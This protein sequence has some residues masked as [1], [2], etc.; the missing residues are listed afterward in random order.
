MTSPTDTSRQK[1]ACQS[2]GARTIHVFNVARNCAGDWIARIS[3]NL[4]RKRSYFSTGGSVLT[5]QAPRKALRRPS[6]TPSAMPCSTGTGSPFPRRRPYRARTPT[7]LSAAF[8][9]R[10]AVL[11][12]HERWAHMPARLAP[13]GFLAAVAG[14]SKANLNPR[15]TSHYLINYMFSPAMACE[16]S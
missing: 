14:Q 9:R 5:D 11:T 4:Q 1:I 16:C 7:S 8:A 15:R 13:A 6:L 12:Q 3:S 2:T 10:K